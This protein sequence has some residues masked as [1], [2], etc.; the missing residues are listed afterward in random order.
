M[1]GYR[2]KG[3]LLRRARFKIICMAVIALGVVLTAAS[4]GDD[5]GGGKS[6]QAFQTRGDANPFA[7]PT[8]LTVK[9]SAESGHAK[10]KVAYRWRFDD[11]TF[12][13]EKNPTH[14]FKRPGYYLV[15]LDARDEDANNV[16]QSLLLGAWPPD[17]WTRSQKQPITRQRAI[18]TQR[19]QQARTDKRRA[20]TYLQAR[21][22][23]AQ[24]A[25]A[26]T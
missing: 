5:G 7:G 20:E 4:C 12:S 21:K 15:I 23:A 13:Y 16:R 25:Q 22:K 19:I 6:N 3:Q 2:R 8:P 1:T 17:Q 11:G 14:T 26:G 18:R 10:G 9:F 24:Q